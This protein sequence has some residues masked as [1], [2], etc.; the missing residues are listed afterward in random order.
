MRGIDLTKVT[1]DNQWNGGAFDPFAN[2]GE[3]IQLD[4]FTFVDASAGLLWY[5]LP[6]EFN[7]TYAGISFMHFNTPNTSFYVDNVDEMP[8]RLTAH[9]GADIPLNNNENATWISPKVLFMMQGEHTEL[10]IGGYVKNRLILKS[11]YTNYRKQVEFTWGIGY[12]F[13]DAA[14]VSARVDYGRFGLGV[15]Y[16]INTSSLSSNATGTSSMEFSLCYVTPIRRGDVG[17][18]TNRMPRFF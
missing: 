7:M 11:K 1:W 13:N 8:M 12:R 18:V 16:D 6:N 9:G 4:Q 2:T 5:Y 14:I 15:S 10:T 3:N 17:V